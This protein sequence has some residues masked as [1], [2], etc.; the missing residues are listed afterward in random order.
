MGNLTR[1][2]EVRYTPKGTAVGNMSI[3][4][5]DSFK[6]SDGTTKETVTFVEIELWGRQAETCKQ[7]LTKGKLVFI[8]GKLQLD[9]WE[10]DG[11][12]H[13]R[14]KVRAERVQFLGSGNGRS[15]DSNA[16]QGNVERNQLAPDDDADSIP[17]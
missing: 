9:E 15:E 5:N 11:K 12:K 8:E 13:S 7:Y 1:D 2:P 16:P 3:A 10:K 17:F 6:A 14:L 4:I